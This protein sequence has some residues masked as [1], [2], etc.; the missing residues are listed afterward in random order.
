MVLLPTLGKPTIPQ[1]N[2]TGTFLFLP[3]NHGTG[4]GAAQ[5]GR[6]GAV[7][8]PRSG[9]CGAVV[10]AP[11]STS[12]EPDHQISWRNM[13]R[14][15]CAPFRFITFNFNFNIDIIATGGVLLSSLEAQRNHSLR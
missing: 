13:V 9:P 10:T 14:I 1:F 15:A 4:G 5:Q 6:M 12:S 8:G 3:L 2:G 7:V 11:S